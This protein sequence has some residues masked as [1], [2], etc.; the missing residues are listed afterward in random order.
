MR[1]INLTNIE[2]YRE[3]YFSDADVRNHSSVT[4]SDVFNTGIHAERSSYSIGE[5]RRTRSP[6][7]HTIHTYNRWLGERD[8]G[9]GLS[10]RYANPRMI[11]TINLLGISEDSQRGLASE[12][13]PMNYCNCWSDSI[14]YALW[15]SNRTRTASI[16]NG[17]GESYCALRAKLSNHDLRFVLVCWIVLVAGVYR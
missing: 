3:P 7:R 13:L 2:W 17:P 12:T 8:A 9:G 1:P 5:C 6:E 15:Y 14:R 10:W 16:N 11:N 4:Y